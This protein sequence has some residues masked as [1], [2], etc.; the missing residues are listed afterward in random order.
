MPSC[1]SLTALAN[2]TRDLIAAPAGPVEY[3]LN[4]HYVVLL[5]ISHALQANL[6]SCRKKTSKMGP[7]SGM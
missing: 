6:E 2:A 3:R 4:R 1:P 5:Q 7:S